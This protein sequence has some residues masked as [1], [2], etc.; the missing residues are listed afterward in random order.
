MR[1]LLSLLLVFFFSFSVY[2]QTDSISDLPTIKNI[3]KVDSGVYRCSQPDIS[4]FKELEEAGFKEILNLRRYH[5]DNSKTKETD[6][7][8]HH[9]KIR[10]EAIKE[11][12]LLEAMR[13]IKD[14]EGPILIHCHH[15]SD[16][17]GAVIA[18]YRIIFQ[19]WEK[20]QAIEEMKKGGYGFHKIYFN[21][22][23]LIR[24][25]DVEEFRKK[26]FE[27]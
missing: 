15:G 22:P 7:T 4:N 24:R 6:L 26:V 25:I 18:M 14:R 8:L 27:E 5:S 1:C 13:I 11:K 19:N 17:T 9:I 16:R 3:H 12:H 21:I 23:R 2:A 10:A 20:E